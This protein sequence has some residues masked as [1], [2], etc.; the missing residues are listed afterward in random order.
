WFRVRAKPRYVGRG[1]AGRRDAATG[2]ERMGEGATRK[3]RGALVLCLPVNVSP[4]PASL[5]PPSPRLSSPR[6]RVAPSPLRSAYCILPTAYSS[7]LRFKIRELRC[8]PCS[9]VSSS[10]SSSL[11][12]ATFV[13][14]VVN[15]LLAKIICSMLSANPP[16]ELPSFASDQKAR[17]L[18]H[19]SRPARCPA[20]SMD[21]TES[22][23]HPTSSSTTSHW[24][25]A[26]PLD[27]FGS[28]RPRQITCSDR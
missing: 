26:G 10:V 19:C 21:L 22:L 27:Q 28:T 6:P 9:R 25:T 7:Y 5:L 15:Q 11:F 24:V 14:Y 16:I 17:E 12:S 3:Y 18:K 13:R 23:S 1:D 8:H 20:I 4:P 2:R